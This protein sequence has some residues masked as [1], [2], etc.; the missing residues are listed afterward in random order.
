MIGIKKYG[1]LALM[2]ALGA[3]GML[4]CDGENSMIVGYYE[5]CEGEECE[6]PECE[7]DE[8]DELLCEGEDCDEPGCEGDECISVCEPEC[9]SWQECMGGICRDRGC[10]PKCESW[11]NCVKGVCTD[12]ACSPD[13]IEGQV[14]I[15]GVCLPELCGGTVC[16]ETQ[17]CFDDKCYENSEFCGN[18]ICSDNEKCEGRRCVIHDVCDDIQCPAGHSCVVSSNKI[19]ICYSDACI[20]SNLYKSCQ[21]GTNC[22]NGSC[23]AGTFE[24]P[25]MCD[26][27]LDET[28]KCAI[29]LESITV[30]MDGKTIETVDVLLKSTVTLKVKY[31]PENTTE[32]GVTW[33]TQNV[34]PEDGTKEVSKFLEVSG[35]DQDELILKGISYY[36]GDI[37]IKVV[38]NVNS[39][40]SS[41]AK[42]LVKP[43]YALRPG[44][45]YDDYSTYRKKNLGCNQYN[46]YN[47]SVFNRD[48]Y[49][50]FVQ[51]KMIAR[52]E[53]GVIEYYPT[54]ASV[55]AAAR[56]LSMQFPYDFPYHMES[57]SSNP[58]RSHFAWSSTKLANNVD[59]V[60][61]YGLN[62]TK[63]V[64]NS[65]T[66]EKAIY[67]KSTPWACTI[68][69]DKKAGLECSGFVAWALRNGRFNGGD[70][71]TSMFS[72]TTYKSS[73]KVNA[74]SYGFNVNNKL[75]NT[76]DKFSKLDRKL[77]FIKVKDIKDDQIHAGDL[78]WHG[79]YTKDDGSTGSGHVAF[80]AGVKRKADNSVEYV[81]VAEASKIGNEMVRYTMKSFKSSKW[82]ESKK[83]SCYLIR[84]DN[85]YSYYS[86]KYNLEQSS[87]EY[88]DFW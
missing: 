74:T 50:K 20:A 18:D 71:K 88:D 72:G 31:Y 34:T 44:N 3:L 12:K 8:C 57:I 43:Y 45:A 58:M 82:G 16:S 13:C 52:E 7:G 66:N 70:W 36:A 79:T 33:T 56:F 84:M 26:G 83:Y 61:I 48:L 11:Q 77:D 60:R 69:G 32:K 62:L 14:C 37:D 21:E 35:T 46:E 19:P 54:R 27:F 6:L 25:E 80:V 81:Y 76:V 64:Y 38:S 2:G 49:E 53:N 67:T 17:T 22:V 73:S 41:S 24:L 59:D 68:S 65:H 47:L 42:A 51:P 15:K 75:D 40:I 5:T 86:D 28:G 63:N 23:V 29:P 4:A 30:E 78:L 85:V 9:G 39:G 55:V 10:S 87:N 1:I